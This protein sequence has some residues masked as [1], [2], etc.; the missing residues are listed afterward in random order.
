[1]NAP[2]VKLHP[3]MVSMMMASHKGALS[4]LKNG[5]RHAHKISTP[6][7]QRGQN[8]KKRPHRISRNVVKH[9]AR[10]SRERVVISLTLAAYILSSSSLVSSVVSVIST[11]N[12]IGNS[13]AVGC[14]I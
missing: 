6:N 4:E 7:R 11:G 1:M 9:M 8:T 13:G 3:V 10:P 12:S 2:P 14:S 5:Q